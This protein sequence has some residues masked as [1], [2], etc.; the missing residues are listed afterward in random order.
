[1]ALNRNAVINA[2]LD[3]IRAKVPALKTVSPRPLLY[4]QMQPS[5]QPA[6]CVEAYKQTPTLASPGLPTRWGI[7][8]ALGVCVYNDSATGPLA[9]LNDILDGIESAL[10]ATPEERA[11]RGAYGPNQYL[12]TDLGG[13]VE[14]CRISSAIDTLVGPNEMNPAQGLASVPVEI[15]T[16]S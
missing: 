16:F 9:T 11:A 7:T 15:T 13:T 14:S 10:E 5:D 4:A 2:L 8:I 1:M 3:R 6:L 12:T